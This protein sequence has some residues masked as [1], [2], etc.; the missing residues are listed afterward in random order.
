MPGSLTVKQYFPSLSISSAMVPNPP[1]RPSSLSL[2]G[3]PF[4]LTKI[5][6]PVQSLSGIVAAGPVILLT[7]PSVAMLQQRQKTAQAPYANLK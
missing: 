2:Q 6:C 3:L 1:Q 7:A 5:H 4:T